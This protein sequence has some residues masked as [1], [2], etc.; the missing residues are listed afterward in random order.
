MKVAACQLPGVY[1]DSR[2]ALA[3]VKLYA[4]EAGRSGA[5][6]VCFPECFL[7]GYDVRAERVAQVAIDLT[8]PEFERIL[9]DLATLGP[10]VVMGLIEREGSAFYNTAVAVAAG[11]LIAR[12]RKN[13]LLD[14]ERSIFVAGQSATVFEV[15]GMHVGINICYDLNFSDSIER[16]A[17]AGAELLVCP[18]SNMMP[19]DKAEEWKTRHNEIRARH[20]REHGIWIVSSDVTGARGD[21]IS[22]GPTAVID[23]HG[24]VID[25]VPL[26]QVGMVSAHIDGKSRATLPDA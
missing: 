25:Q 10:A 6:L 18:C 1:D 19:R 8:S 21:R 22:Y 14:G 12:Y 4:L 7:Q 2:R 20:A 24:T 5:D 11:R 9:E 23:S 15:A 26:M 17:A 3:V 13:H 16:A